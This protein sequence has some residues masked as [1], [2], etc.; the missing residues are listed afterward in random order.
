[1]VTIIVVGITG[2]RTTTARA[3][4]VAVL[5]TALITVA[6]EVL[7]LALRTV[8]VTLTVYAVSCIYIIIVSHAYLT[9]SSQHFYLLAQICPCALKIATVMGM[10]ILTCQVAGM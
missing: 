4:V 1:M 5:I 7:Q 10:E 6:Q 9:G 3:T 2:G 8:T